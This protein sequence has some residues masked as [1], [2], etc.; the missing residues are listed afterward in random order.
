MI[1]EFLEPVE[2]QSDNMR[3]IPIRGRKEFLPSVASMGIAGSAPDDPQLELPLAQAQPS[4]RTAASETDR[5]IRFPRKDQ[6]NPPLPI[7]PPEQLGRRTRRPFT[8]SGF[9]MGCV[10]GSAAAAVLLLLVRIVI[11]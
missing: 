10:L 5:I 3:Y 9:L 4:E 6:V 7:K 2:D 1:H 11:N 8:V